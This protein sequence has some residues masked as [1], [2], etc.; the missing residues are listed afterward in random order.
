[1]SVPVFGG[2][3][4]VVMSSFAGRSNDART[5]LCILVAD[6]ISEY[7]AYLD[8]R[9]LLALLMTV[10]C[11]FM[12]KVWFRGNCVKVRAP[13]KERWWHWYGRGALI[14]C[15]VLPDVYTPFVR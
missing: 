8:S 5:Q 4:G 6:I 3:A 15:G 2:Y 11:A 10:E 7:G 14:C 12:W 1:M 13:R 9:G